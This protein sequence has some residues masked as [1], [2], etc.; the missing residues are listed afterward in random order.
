VKNLWAPWRYAW[1]KESSRGVD[2]CFICDALQE[3]G[4]QDRKNLVLY[5]GKSCLVIMNRY[6]YSN[7][8][9]MIAPKRHIADP[10]QIKPEEWLETGELTQIVLEALARTISPHGF[11]LGW[12]IGQIAGAGL[13]QHLHQHIVPRWEGDTNYLPV[14]GKTKV[15]SQDLWECYDLLVKTFKELLNT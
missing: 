1:I 14:L 12:N 10:R 9:V 4:D 2:N 5:R 6:P 13:E 15:I 8:H 7:G 3:S 11:N